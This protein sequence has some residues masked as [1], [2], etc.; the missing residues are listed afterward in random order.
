MSNIDQTLGER[1]GRYGSI[2]M[3]SQFTQEMMSLVE[4]FD[5][6]RPIDQK[7]SYV[8]RECLHMI[9]HKIARMVCGD[10]WYADNAHDIAGYAKLLEEFINEQ[11]PEHKESL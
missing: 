4:T 7:L 2:G 5:D 8:H 9:F 6:E 3:N 10:C 1:G 11:R